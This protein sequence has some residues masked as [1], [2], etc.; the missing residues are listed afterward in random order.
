MDEIAA[1]VGLDKGTLYHYFTSKRDILY[2]I[3]LE[4]IEIAHEILPELDEPTPA[5]AAVDRFIHHQLRTIAKRPN[6]SA[7]YTQESRHLQQWLRP[8]QLRTVRAGEERVSSALTAV[9][10][11]GVANGTFRDVPPRVA[12]D[13]VIGMCAW[14]STRRSSRG[15]TDDVAATFATVVL[16]GLLNVTT[17]SGRS[18][19]H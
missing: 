7:V 10:A 9:I 15:S 14:A 19:P 8:D 18:S 2:E 16:G 11:R 6:E 17:S 13:G 4:S 1:G 3:L 12:A 5:G